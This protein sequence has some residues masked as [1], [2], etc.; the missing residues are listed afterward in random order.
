M[1]AHRNVLQG[2]QTRH[3]KKAW[4]VWFGLTPWSVR[5]A[6]I[7]CS[8]HPSKKMK[9]GTR[10]LTQLQQ[11]GCGVN[12]GSCE[13]EERA[14]IETKRTCTT[15][16]FKPLCQ[17]SFSPPDAV[18][19]CPIRVVPAIGP[20]VPPFWPCKRF[21][22]APMACVNRHDHLSR[23][24]AGPQAT[25]A[26]GI[27]SAVPQTYISQSTQPCAFFYAPFTRHSLLYTP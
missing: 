22:Q 4:L 25:T 21:S 15:P 24:C 7:F 14:R 16:G 20:P 8:I 2:S 5:L 17:A 11:R 27:S 12:Q 6:S 26:L 1:K 9:I 13:L 18:T 23:G 10:V 19:R 3:P